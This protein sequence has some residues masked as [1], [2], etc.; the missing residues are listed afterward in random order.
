MRVSSKKGG[1]QRKIEGTYSD[2][3]SLKPNVNHLTINSVDPGGVDIRSIRQH[4]W[5]KEKEKEKE[6][7]REGEDG[8]LR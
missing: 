4:G 1:A 3:S 8:R 2:L 7:G 5:L 6:N